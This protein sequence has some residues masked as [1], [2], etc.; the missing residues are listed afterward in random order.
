MTRMTLEALGL[1]HDYAADR[2][3]RFRRYDEDL[4]KKQAL[5]YDD[6]TKLIQSTRDALVDLQKLFEADAEPGAERE[7]EKGAVKPEES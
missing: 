3:E 2:V 4:L 5:V 7:R 6:E 1:P